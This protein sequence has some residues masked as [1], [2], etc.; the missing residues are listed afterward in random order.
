MGWLA[1]TTVVAGNLRGHM[2]FRIHAPI[3][4]LVAIGFGFWL[5]LQLGLWSSLCF[6]RCLASDALLRVLAVALQLHELLNIR[7]NISRV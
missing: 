1:K 6:G 5:A 7:F 3:V 2:P 4:R